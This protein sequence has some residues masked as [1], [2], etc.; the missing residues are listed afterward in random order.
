VVDDDPTIRE[1]AGTVLMSAGY[2]VVSAVDGEDALAKLRGDPMH[3]DAVLLDLTMP[4]LDGEDTLMALR[5]ISPNLP[6]VL[7]SG[8]GE[9]AV[10]QRFVGRG[11]ADFLPKPFVTEALLTVIQTVI[12]RARLATA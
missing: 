6:V 4:K 7:T 10:V 11:L 12:E 2:A 8:Y 5:M 1:F 3:F 9:Q